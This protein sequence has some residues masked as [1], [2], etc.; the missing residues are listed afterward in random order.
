M[1]TIQRR[2]SSYNFSN[3][4]G[5]SIK[6]IVLHYTGNRGDTAKNN[7]DYFYGGNRNASA[8]YF[9]DDN[10]IW[11][12]VEESNAAWAVGDGRGA[13][14]IQNQNSISI[15][16]CCNSNGVI[17]EK[18]ENDALELV[19]YLQT[20]YNI[21]NDNVVRHYDA[22]RK[23][24]PNWSSNNWS[25]WWSFKSKLSG[26]SS[27][28]VDNTSNT[29]SNN[30]SNN[31]NSNNNI[32]IANNYLVTSYNIKLVQLLLNCFGWKLDADG[33]CGS[34]TANAIGEFQSKYN[35]TKDYMFGAECFSKSY[36]LI[37]NVICK[38]GKFTPN[39]TK[40]IQHVLGITVDG[41]FANNTKAAVINF[42]KSKK[43]LADGIVGINT[44]SKLLG[45]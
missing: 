16:M 24:C 17:S 20:K 38:Y 12:C 6:Y 4:N 11:Q 43:L 33:I 27:N 39:Q 32:T 5:N 19:K 29:N 9:V 14:G 15:E 22:S 25:R 36:T 23:L 21:S 3:R 34:L 41:I 42:Q 2:I 35:L 31:T 7:V 37:K 45:L 10:S 13:Y 26:N 18:T 1:L 28:V 40:V 30:N 44:W 8:H